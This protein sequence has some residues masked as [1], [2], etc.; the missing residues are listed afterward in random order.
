M[1]GNNTAFW[2][3]I[4][5][6]LLVGAFLSYLVLVYP[7]PGR[8]RD[9][10]GFPDTQDAFPDDPLEWLDSDGDGIGDN[11]DHVPL[12]DADGDLYPDEEDAF[13]NDPKEWQDADRNGVGDN[14][15]YWAADTDGDGFGDVIDLFPSEDMGIYFNVTE[16]GVADETDYLDDVAEVYFELR[17]NGH[18]EGRLDNMGE[19]WSCAVGSHLAV[20]ESYRFNVDDNRRYTS[21]EVTMIDDDVVSNDVLDLDGTSR[22]G[23]TLNVT[24]DI[25]NRTWRGNDANGVADGSLDGTASSDD[26]DGSMRFSLEAAAIDENRTYRWTFQGTHYSM[27]AV[28]PPRAYAEYGRMDVPRSYYFGYSDEDVQT[29]VTSDDPIVVSIANEL[30]NLSAREGFSEVETINF[31]LRFCQSLGYSYDNATMGADE[32]WRFPVETLY[33]E[34]GDCEDTSFLFA[35]VAEAMGYDAVILLLPGHAAVGIASDQGS[36]SY[37]VEGGT[38]YYY[39]ETTSPGFELGELPLGLDTR[40]VDAVQVS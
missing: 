4:A 40:D 33:D 18:D 35:S 3:A 25:V 19:A 10:D 38:R 26:D 9:E 22:A 5:A 30:R 39:C 28:V 20:N 13:P 24:F 29:F 1:N 21:F 12:K 8:D 7:D 17:A 16:I 6:M 36:G 37:F 11:A 23:R 32:Y 27:N 15:E 34:T 31:A 14:A 2:A